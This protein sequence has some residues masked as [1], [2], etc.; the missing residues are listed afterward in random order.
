MCGNCDNFY[1]A[2]WVT[3]LICDKRVPAGVKR[4]IYKTKVR[5]AMLYVL[6]MVSRKKRQEAALEVAEVM[7]LRCVL[8]VNRLDRI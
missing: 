2:V 8:G 5:P 6:E 3:R 4:K 1:F 7:M